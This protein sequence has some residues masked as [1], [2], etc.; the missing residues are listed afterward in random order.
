MYQAAHFAKELDFTAHDLRNADGFKM[1]KVASIL[2]KGNIERQERNVPRPG[3]CFEMP[4]NVPTIFVNT[5]AG[6]ENML[7][8]FDGEKVF[9]FDCENSLFTGILALIQLATSKRV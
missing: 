2:D 9:G 5:N 4:S 3:S 6:F 1:N 8:D 7:N